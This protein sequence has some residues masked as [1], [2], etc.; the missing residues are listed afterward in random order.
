MLDFIRVKA[1]WATDFEMTGPALS[2]D[3]RAACVFAARTEATVLMRGRERFT[4]A[5]E[6]SVK[7]AWTSGQTSRWFDSADPLVKK[8]SET[9][10]GPVLEQLAR[11]S[12]HQDT[13][14]VN[15]FREG[16]PL[17]G[18]LSHSGNGDE[19]QY[20]PHDDIQ[21]LRHH[22]AKNNLAILS[23]L[24]DDDNSKVLLEQARLC[25]AFW[26]L[27][28]FCQTQVHRRFAMKW[29]WVVCA[30]AIVSHTVCIGL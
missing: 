23:S 7:E 29:S 14:C 2:D 6:Q 25:Y 18:M 26:H 22:A 19:T 16:A 11:L 21:S 3:L 15:S 9:V 12:G 10:C 8:V 5:V 28:F 27:S 17:L 20:P 4:V 24:K 13:A 1:E 30:S